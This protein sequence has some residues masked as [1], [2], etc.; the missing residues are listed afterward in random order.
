MGRGTHDLYTAWI[1]VGNVP[2]SDGPLA[3]LENSH[4]LESLKN[5]YGALDVDRDRDKDPYGGGRLSE[6]PVEVQERFGG[7]WLTAEF[8]A[9]DL[10]L[11]TM[12]T[13]HCSLDNVSPRVR[14]STDSR[15]QRASDPAD[16]RWIGEDAVGHGKQARASGKRSP[17]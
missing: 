6:S 5:T 15:Y 4:R 10:L 14:L 11:F 8:R 9:G 2:S 13:L 7:R 12:F 16:G 17:E 3:I 1:L